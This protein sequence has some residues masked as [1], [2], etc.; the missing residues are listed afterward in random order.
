MTKKQL[1][2]RIENLEKKYRD[3]I[4]S[5]NKTVDRGNEQL[6]LLAAKFDCQ[7][8]EEEYIG[9]KDKSPYA[10]LY[11]SW[12]SDKIVKTRYVLKPIKK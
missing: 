7:F 1:L 10:S 11:Y 12:E 6:N 8:E 5:A 3:L 9:H 2:E 4:N